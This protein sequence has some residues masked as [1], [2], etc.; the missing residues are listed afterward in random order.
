MDEIIDVLKGVFTICIC[1]LVIY[2][3]CVKEEK[4]EIESMVPVVVPVSSYNEP[5]SKPSEPSEPSDPMETPRKYKQCPIC[6]GQGR[7]MGCGGSGQVYSVFYGDEV[8]PSRLTECGACG[9]TGACGFCG[10]SGMVEDLGW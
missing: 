1:A 3:K 6:Y 2:T 4:K 7:C 8:G 5:D 10:G 9:G